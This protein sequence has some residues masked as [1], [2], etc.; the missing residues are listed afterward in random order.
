MRTMGS[1][2]A[3]I[4]ILSAGMTVAAAVPADGSAIARLGEQV[5]AVDAVKTITA[6]ETKKPKIPDFATA[7]GA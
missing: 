1:M 6:T 7:T 3:A 4:A 5:N 2:A